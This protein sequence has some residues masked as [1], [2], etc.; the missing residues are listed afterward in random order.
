[1]VET[2][3]VLVGGATG[4]QGGALARQLL[5]RGHRVRA[6]TR[7]PN[8]PAAAALRR[9]GA[10]IASGDL[11]DPVS[12][13]VAATGADAVFVVATPF[14]AGPEGETRQANNLIDAA[15]AAS[16]PHIV[17]SSV[18][19]ADRGTGVPH[20]ESK[21][22][23]EQ[24]LRASGARYTIM[25]PAMFMDMLLAPWSMPSLQE[26]WIGAPLAPDVP[27]Q[28]VAVTDIGAF[29]ALVIEQPERFAGQRIEIA[30]DASTGPELAARLGRHIVR[31]V[32]YVV[33][34]IDQ[35][36]DEDLATMYRFLA[37]E[38]YRV[39]IEALRRAYPEVG[40]HD[41]DDWAAEQAWAALLRPDG[42]A[43]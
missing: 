18:A 9:A 1:M 15:V 32:R 22:A 31:E 42:V 40:W 23:V 6:L 7:K 43:R 8:G 36:G 19:S 14:E 11:D 35:A 3:T 29:A 26:G 21:F 24:H 28:R 4:N 38:G 25:A 5:R 37:D 13:R 16:V 39:D 30:G 34:P 20:F 2:R 41:L 17:Y 10:E 33:T 12:L 27:T